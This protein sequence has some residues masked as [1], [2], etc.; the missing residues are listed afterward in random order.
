M[1]L[2]A[3]NVKAIGLLKFKP[4]LRSIRW[5]GTRL[6]AFK[7]LSELP[8]DRIGESWEISGLKGEETIIAEGLFSG[9]T[10]TE[11]LYEYGERLLGNRLYNKFGNF[12]PLLIK[13]IDA[14]D[15]LSIQ[16]HPGDDT[17]P[18]GHG[19]TEL[20]YIIKSEPGSYIYSGFNRPVDRVKLEKFMEN[21]RLVNVVAKHFSSSGDVF[22]IPAGRIHSI[23]AG[24]LLLEIQQTSGITYRLHDYNRKDKDGKLRELH[25]EQALNVIDYSQTDYGLARPQLLID[26]ETRI[27]STPYFTLS[28]VQIMDK[29]RVDV[30]EKD[31]P[32]IIIAIQ[33]SGK[34]TDSFGNTSMI[35]QGQT[36]LVPAETDFVDIKAISTPLKVITVYIE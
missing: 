34:L 4:I 1:S 25:V 31:S 11:L 30:R 19:K 12:F 15:D 29:V 2:D 18:N 10:I 28:G 33:G 20:W 21:N 27:K 6:G 22:Y 3:K 32:R 14:E 5:G 35:H 23:G 36:I 9:H 24:N 17:A 26:Y 8:D 13:F 7:G 16:V